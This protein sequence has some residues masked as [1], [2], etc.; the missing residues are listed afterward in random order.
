VGED[1][2]YIWYEVI[3]RDEHHPAVKSVRS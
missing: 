1:G 2:K 3:M